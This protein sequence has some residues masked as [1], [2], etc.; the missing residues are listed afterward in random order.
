[1]DALEERMWWYRALHARLIDALAGVQ[2]RVLDAGCGTGGLLASL[3]THSQWQPVGVEYEPKAARRARAKAALPV[4]SGSINALPF[5][6]AGFA[7]AVVADV[8]CHK[9]VDPGAALAELHRVLRPGGLIVVNMPAY[10]W[11]FSAHDKRVQNIRRQTAGE[12]RRMLEA[13]G[14]VRP[15]LRYWNG[16]LLP[17]MIIQRKLRARRHDSASDVAMFPP[18][19]DATFHAITEIERRSRLVLPAGGSILG[20]AVRP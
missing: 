10:A 8:L 16:L 4:V 20:I 11:L 15:I 6:D 2:G 14:F 5:A 7:A 13:A 9:S 12:L 3:A 18:W 19:L 1:M 17:L